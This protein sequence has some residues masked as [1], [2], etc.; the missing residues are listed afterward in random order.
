MCLFNILTQEG[1]VDIMHETMEATGETV[2]PFVAMLFILY[3]MFMIGV[4]GLATKTD[5]MP[6][7]PPKKK[8]KKEKKEKTIIKS[9]K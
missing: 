6:C 4:S 1:W 7:P 8:R 9:V 3:H 2:A 5:N